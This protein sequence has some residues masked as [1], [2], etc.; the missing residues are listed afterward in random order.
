MECNGM[1]EDDVE[2]NIRKNDARSPDFVNNNNVKGM[3]KM[4]RLDHGFHE[5]KLELR[6]CERRWGHFLFCL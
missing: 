3:E 6:R 1:H 5:T 2:W 4:E